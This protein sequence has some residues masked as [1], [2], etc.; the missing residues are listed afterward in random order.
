MTRTPAGAQ[1]QQASTIDAFATSV[2]LFLTFSWGLNQVAVKLANVG[3]NP[4]FSVLLRSVIAGVLVWLWCRYRR[5]PLF[6]RDGTLWAGIA[7]GVLFGAEFV[8]IF[9]GLDHTSA[10]RGTL[11]INTMPFWV[12]LGGHFF[13][14]ERISLQKFLGLALAFSGVVVV[15]S[16]TLTLPGPDAF[17][18]DLMCLGAG[19]LWAG[20]VLVIK[21]SRLST[22]SAEK[23]LLYQ[24]LVSAIFALPFIS[25]AGPVF[26]D[27]GIVPTA[28]LAFQAI[29]I[30]AFTY[31]LWFW[32]MRRYPVSSLSSFAFLTPAF[33]V[34]CAGLLLNEPLSIRIFAALALIAVGLLVVNRPMRRSPPG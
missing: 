27:V 34:L 14:N 19:I 22:A 4:I 32:L 6:E 9:V 15:F 1:P 10:A 18:G 31:L 24:L 7:A 11:M 26:R 8:L 2:M 30:V 12:L 16:D 23:T 13:L 17:M 33:G 3:Y 28:A 20:T 5:I 29:F 21:G 25:L